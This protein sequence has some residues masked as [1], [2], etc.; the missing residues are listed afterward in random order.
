MAAC[1]KSEPERASSEATPPEPAP[2]PVPA[3]PLPDG[4]GKTTGE[5]SE[6]PAGAGAPGTGGV[7]E[8]AEP[9]CPGA[10]R[11]EE[12]LDA[13]KSRGVAGCV[14]SDDAAGVAIAGPEA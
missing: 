3:P 2:P 6:G 11:P 7:E 5:P 12:G 10:G 1:S 14:P 8:L 13:E 9:A 4:V